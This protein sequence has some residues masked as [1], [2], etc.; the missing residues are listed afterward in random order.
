MDDSPRNSIA[1]ALFKDSIT[2]LLYDRAKVWYLTNGA[3]ERRLGDLT[4]YE[5]LYWR[6]IVRSILEGTF[7]GLISPD[8][9][10]DH[11]SMASVFNYTFFSG[12]NFVAGTMEIDYRNNKFSGTIWEMCTDSEAAADLTSFYQFKYLYSTT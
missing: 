7:Y 4:T 10:G 5:N 11:V 12:L 3:D 1:G 6:R 9:G 8:T 2:N